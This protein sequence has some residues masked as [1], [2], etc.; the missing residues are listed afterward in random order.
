M[1]EE[2]EVFQ[3]LEEFSFF[4]ARIL[5]LAGPQSYV[6]T[7]LTY[8]MLNHS[9]LWFPH[10]IILAIKKPGGGD[11]LADIMDFANI[12]AGK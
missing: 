3:Y 5:N 2:M 7:Y 1:K 9:T 12:L 4:V 6:A 8:S 11:S 10:R